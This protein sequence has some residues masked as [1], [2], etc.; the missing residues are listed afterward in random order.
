MS[1][2]ERV[3]KSEAE[4]LEAGFMLSRDTEEELVGRENS[5]PA[6]GNSSSLK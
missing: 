4:A 5:K 2:F 6:D 1:V 3:L